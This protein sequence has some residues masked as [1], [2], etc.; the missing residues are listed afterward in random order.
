MQVPKL[1][2]KNPQK[3]SEYLLS[4]NTTVK[5]EEGRKELCTGEME[6][7]LKKKKFPQMR[8]T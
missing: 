7:M 8:F 2:K 6:G 5:K 4:L 1:K 3:K